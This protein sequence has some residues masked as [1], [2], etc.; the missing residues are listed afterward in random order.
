M[1]VVGHT[2]GDE[3][4]G[5][6]KL[7]HFLRSFPVAAVILPSRSCSMRS[8]TCAVVIGSGKPPVKT[9]TIPF[10]TNSPPVSVGSSLKPF[11]S[12]D[13]RSLSPGK[14]LNCARRGLG[15]I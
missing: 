10:R 15:S 4:V 6:K 3:H 11:P 9:K 12:T 8:L 14:R 2:G 13:K 5:I 7:L 1:F